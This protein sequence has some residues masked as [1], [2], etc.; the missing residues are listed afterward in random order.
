[1]TQ[2]LPLPQTS[3]AVFLTD[4]GIETDLIFNRGFELPYFA[5]FD[6]L[7]T[8]EGTEALRGYFHR[9]ASI[10]RE[11]GMGFIFESPTWRASADWGEKLGYGAA[12]LFDANVRAIGLMQE[13]KAAYT[14]DMPMV[15]SGCIG[16]RGDGY[17]PGSLMTAAEAEAYHA[18]QAGA[19]AA[20][21]VDLATAIT[22]TNTPE[23]I[24][25]ARAAAAAGLQSVISFTLETNGHLPTGESLQA[26]IE[27]VDAATGASPAYYMI[28]C[29]H[30]SHFDDIL[31]GDKGWLSRLRGVRANASRKSHAELDESESLDDGD[32]EELGAQYATLRRRLPNLSVLG[33]CC[34]T[35]E[36]H[37]G[38]I[39]AACR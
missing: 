13:V 30:P 23:A 5:A 8:R 7:K 35:D 14:T 17:D 16:P 19:F 20:A 38:R 15:V 6:L 29:A 32:P 10:A 39:A 37:I 11:H 1:M 18:A 26:A 36:R 24:G 2:T 25:V 12:A 21:G 22:M 34:G 9:H 3:G 28:N 4:G 27:A 31:S 33:G